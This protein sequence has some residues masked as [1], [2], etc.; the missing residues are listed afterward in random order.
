MLAASLP[1]LLAPAAKAPASVKTALSRGVTEVNEL[2]AVPILEYHL[3]GRPEGPWR[4]TPENF[5]RDLAMLYGMGYRPVRLLDY[6]AG[7]IDIPAGTSPLIL[8][9]D[10]SSEG[11]FRAVM[12]DG[13]PQPD[14]DSAVGMIEEFARTHPDFKARASFYVLPGIGKRLALFGQPE[15]RA[16]KLNYLV[17]HAYELGNHTFW[18]QNLAKAQPQDVAKQLA[19]A[20]KA[21]WEYVPGYQLQSLSLPFGAWPSRRELVFSGSFEGVSYRN[22]AVLLVGAGPAPAPA[23]RS[24]NPNALPRIQAGDGVFGPEQTLLRLQRGRFGRYISDGKPDVLSIPTALAG[25]LKPRL[26]GSSNHSVV[27]FVPLRD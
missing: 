22:R 25:R 3:I 6:I 18:H 1:A 10:D 5:R 19:E 17:K 23:D 12:V 16:W 26:P 15:L 8:T 20:Q 14:P 11:Q 9:F 21:I 4:R 24:F 13:H 27:F 7:R 2:G